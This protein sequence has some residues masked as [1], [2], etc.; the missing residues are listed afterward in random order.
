MDLLETFALTP[1]FN[2]HIFNIIAAKIIH[3]IEIWNF[4][5]IFHFFK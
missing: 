2:N 1:Y 4:K 3:S 5:K